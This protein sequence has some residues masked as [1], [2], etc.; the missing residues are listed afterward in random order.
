MIMWRRHGDCTGGGKLAGGEKGSQINKNARKLAMQKQ[1]SKQFLIRDVSSENLRAKKVARENRSVL[2][3]SAKT[4]L[5]QA[6]QTSQ[7]DP[8]IVSTN[9]SMPIYEKTTKANLPLLELALQELVK[10]SN[11]SHNFWGEFLA[12]VRFFAQASRSQG[13][14]RLNQSHS[15]IYLYIQYNDKARRHDCFYSY[16]QLENLLH[17]F[18][19]VDSP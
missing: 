7:D 11:T 19:S 3:L 18:S 2:P 4:E 17:L 12:L 13:V 10:A 8:T 1:R 9:N 14:I 16:G 6:P 5:K 15:H